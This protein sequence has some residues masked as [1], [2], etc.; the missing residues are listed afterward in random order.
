[1]GAAFEIFKKTTQRKQSAIGKKF[2]QSGHSGA[3]A[4]GSQGV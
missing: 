3:N 2:A 1:M 4:Y